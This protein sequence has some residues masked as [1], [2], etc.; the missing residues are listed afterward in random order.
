MKKMT[1]HQ[2][3]QG[4]AI[5]IVLGILT[6]VLVLGLVFVGT[7][8]N[9]RL[10]SMANAD[11]AKA[12]LLAESAAARAEA[13]TYYL[14]E[15]SLDN[16]PAHSSINDLE[17]SW[18]PY[19]GN[20]QYDDKLTDDLD[21]DQHLPVKIMHLVGQGAT[22]KERRIQNQ[23]IFYTH[24]SENRQDEKNR[25]F[26]DEGLLKN[27]KY[28][29]YIFEAASNTQQ[30]SD[31]VPGD[32]NSETNKRNFT[33]RNM[34]DA[35]G[36]V[37]GRYAFLMFAEGAKFNVNQMAMASQS[38]YSTFV[39]SVDAGK[40]TTN[41]NN[42][43]VQLNQ[44]KESTFAI[45]GY[46]YDAS[47]A[48]DGL[49]DSG[50]YAEKETL[51]Y[52]LHPQEL[53]V[54]NDVLD[55]ANNLKLEDEDCPP[56]YFNYD[57]MLAVNEDLWTDGNTNL[58]DFFSLYTLY[59]GSDDREVVFHGNET[60]QE[61]T[62]D[63]PK[64]NLAYPGK[65]GGD[66]YTWDDI[67]KELNGTDETS[68]KNVSDFLAD[69]FADIFG[70]ALKKDAEGTLF[71]NDDGNDITSAVF[72]NLVDF[73]DSD[74]LITYEATVGA[75]S[76]RLEYNSTINYADEINVKSSG[77]ERVPAIIG[78]A[79]EPYEI[80]RF[81]RN[82]SIAGPGTG[83]TPNPGSWSVHGDKLK[84]RVGLVLQNYFN[85]EVAMPE[86]IKVVVHGAFNPFFAGRYYYTENG[87]SGYRYILF[88]SSYQGGSQIDNGCPL[89]NGYNDIG[90]T[91]PSL[92][93]LRSNS[94]EQVFEIS[95]SN[96]STYPASNKLNARQVWQAMVSFEKDLPTFAN[97]YGN[98][99]V[100][101]LYWEI[102]D[103]IVMAADDNGK[104]VDL[105]HLKGSDTT[106]TYLYNCNPLTT[107]VVSLKNNLLDD[108][109]WPLVWAVAKDP[110]SNHA[111]TDWVWSKDYPATAA[112]KLNKW[113]VNVNVSFGNWNG[114]LYSD[115]DKG[116]VKSVSD[117]MSQ[118][119]RSYA[120]ACIQEVCKNSNSG[121]N[122]DLEP[123]LKFEFTGS[124]PA[125]ET[126][127]T[128]STAFIPN[129]PITSLWQLGAVSRGE[130]ARTV[131]LKKYG[132]PKG[133]QKYADGDA[134]LLD[135]FKLN[136]VA[137]DQAIPG[138]FN[139]NC[140]NALSYRYLLANIPANPN[141]NETAVYQPG[142][143]KDQGIDVVRNSFY[144]DWVEAKAGDQI[145]DMEDQLFKFTDELNYESTTLYGK[146]KDEWKLPPKQAEKQ[147][148][149]PVEAFFNFVKIEDEPKYKT[150]TAQ[151]D[152]LP[153]GASRNANDRMA[154]SL[155]GCTAGLLSTRYEY[156]TVFA[157]GQNLKYLGK[158]TTMN[159]EAFKNQLINPIELTVDGEKGWYSILATQL[160]LITIQRDCWK[161]EM[162]IVRNQLY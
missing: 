92:N 85:E 50:E 24:D 45:S 65:P 140:F 76:N 154:E 37:M 57:S 14:Q 144:Y 53:R 70:K 27:T 98:V 71:K 19:A 106:T 96:C 112:A 114:N 25:P 60:I 134:W 90:N 152:S 64:I 84:I 136:E 158:L 56:Q 79:V 129:H 72:A 162:K 40:V 111:H 2:N 97:G 135:Y 11:N 23:Y 83:G 51:Q 150:A 128:F 77:N 69:S 15:K 139:P 21:D 102:K 9:A 22:A 49:A 125:E 104:L 91:E 105:A 67:S 159:N 126:P 160:R 5:L 155:I 30:F 6:L 93:V 89:P 52:G 16:L 94:L 100:C 131:N 28:G 121:N 47:G 39:P 54:S 120:L 117:D 116:F 44:E 36:H 38:G 138:K 122:K 18:M 147:S 29:N 42:P 80:N 99:Q 133:G 59:S 137:P 130:P 157:I 1:F 32:L 132:G 58:L 101:G 74:D 33:Y 119:L 141:P 95:A 46:E 7:S 17:Y 118:N 153:A 12:A 151:E 108:K 123:E 148:W 34:L 109:G 66:R 86:K 81:A 31:Y 143:L 145:V 115:L 68:P 103:I 35:D 75:S 26:A 113:G 124:N 13:V 87:V 43:G 3:E 146:A 142:R 78:V 41:A 88:G 48:I 63:S 110:R 4:S 20:F 62:E 127:N 82:D 61:C 10:I 156:F 149:S 8:R 107:N 161:N 55:L 73:C